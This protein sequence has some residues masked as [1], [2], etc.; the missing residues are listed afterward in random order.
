MFQVQ[1]VFDHFKIRA[2][3]INSNSSLGNWKAY[4]RAQ[5]H[6]DWIE[7][8]NINMDQ[9]KQLLGRWENLTSDSC[10]CSTRLTASRWH[11]FTTTLSAY[12]INPF[13]S[14]AFRIF[15]IFDLYSIFQILRQV[16]P[17]AGGVAQGHS[18]ARDASP[19]QQRG[20]V[21][22]VQG[23]IPVYAGDGVIILMN[24]TE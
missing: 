1:I 6:D 15:Y 11:G 4:G 21:Q 8:F 18:G 19:H 9:S 23:Q 16:L 13:R 17:R 3:N 7:I 22:R 20:R 5:C 12:F 2:D 10:Q 14:I 24:E